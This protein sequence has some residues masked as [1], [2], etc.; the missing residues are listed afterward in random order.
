VRGIEALIGAAQAALV[1]ARIALEE[2]GGELVAASA[3]EPFV[4]DPTDVPF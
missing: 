4:L 1:R 2:I 3:P